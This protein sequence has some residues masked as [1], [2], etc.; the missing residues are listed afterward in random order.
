M[1]HID[2]PPIKDPG[3]PPP[4]VVRLSPETIEAIA[5]AVAAKVIAALKP[6]GE[7]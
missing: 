1:V 7:S 2:R 6:G 3:P 5:E 4:Q